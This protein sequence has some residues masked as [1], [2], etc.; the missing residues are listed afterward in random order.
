MALTSLLGGGGGVWW[1]DG[2]SN[3]LLQGLR[4]QGVGPPVGCGLPTG[5]VTGGGPP[6]IHGVSTGSERGEGLR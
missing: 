3:A 4:Y 2:H 5:G 1:G 6:T